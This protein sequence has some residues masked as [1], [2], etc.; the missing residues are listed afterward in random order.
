MQ[1]KTHHKSTGVPSPA[2]LLVFCYSQGLLL[3]HQLLLG[4]LGCIVSLSLLLPLQ[5]LLL[6]P[7][8]PR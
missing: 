2:L 4:Q 7:F 5:L 1:W 3:N 6:L 8:G